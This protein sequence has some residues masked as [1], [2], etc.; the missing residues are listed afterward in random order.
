M[1]S[2]GQKFFGWA[3]DPLAA[4]LAQGLAGVERPMTIIGH[5]QGTL[6]IRNA[7]RYYGLPGG[8]TFVMRSPAMSYWS[9]SVAARVNAGTL[10]YVQPWG[11]IANLYA[12]TMNPLK[13]MSGFRDVLCGACTH[14]ANGLR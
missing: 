10:Q 13:W 7:A 11:D 12:P 2:F 1:E 9:A 4:G 5:S 8:S 6:T 3:G 14:T